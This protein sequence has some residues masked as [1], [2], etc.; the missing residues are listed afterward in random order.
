MRTVPGNVHVVTQNR[1][2]GVADLPE[3]VSFALAG[4]AGLAR[5]SCS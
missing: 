2:A 1:A 3:E 4:I 5:E